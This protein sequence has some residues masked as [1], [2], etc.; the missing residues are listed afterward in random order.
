MDAAD[1][2]HESCLL[3]GPRPRVTKGRDYADAR[4]ATGIHAPL[5]TTA[6]SFRKNVYVLGAGFSADAGAPVMRDFFSRARHLKDDPHSGLFPQEREIFERVIQYRFEL[7]RALA[8]VLV[9]LDNI[10]QLFGFL[11][12]ELRL[13]PQANARLRSDMIYVIARTLELTSTKA[14]SVQQ[15]SLLSDNVG[16]RRQHRF[17]GNQYGFFAGFASGRWNPAKQYEGRSVDSVVSFNYDLILEREMNSLGI[18]PAYQCTAAA[19][20]EGFGEPKL[21]VKLLKMHGSAN[22]VHCNQCDVLWA[23]SPEKAKQTELASQPCPSCHQ[24]ERLT[25]VIVPPTWNKGIEAKFILPVWKEVLNELTSAGRLFIIGY[26]FPESDQFFKYLLGLA[27]SKNSSL[28]EIHVVSDSDKIKQRFESQFHPYFHERVVRYHT[29]G[30][31]NFLQ[32]IQDFTN[33]KFD[34]GALLGPHFL[35]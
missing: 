20:Y 10:E 26:S 29:D 4:T 31:S 14:L 16:G 19:Y 15:H 27:L 11:E 35:L 6:V 21:H 34:E 17:N 1:G 13:S 30:S 23:F 25:S 12:M 32:R 3:V 22:W 28:T 2:E 7:D 5:R 9:D 33:Q 18:G 24:T 8:K